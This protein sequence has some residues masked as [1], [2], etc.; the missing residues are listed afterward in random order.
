MQQ[1]LAY[2]KP[3]FIC[4]EQCDILEGYL[5]AALPTPP[6]KIVAA[7]NRRQ[8]LTIIFNTVAVFWRRSW[9]IYRSDPHSIQPMSLQ[10]HNLRI[11]FACI[12]CAH[13]IDGTRRCFHIHP[14]I[15]PSIHQ[16]SYQRGTQTLNLCRLRRH[17][18][19]HE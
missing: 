11:R 16:A 2:V 4:A 10:N 9:C 7:N 8:S 5:R 6:V 14:S 15:H 3:Y 1:I 12:A 18:N 19:Y 17:S 13:G